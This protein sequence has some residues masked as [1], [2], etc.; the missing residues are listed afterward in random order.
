MGAKPLGKICVATPYRF[1]SH[2]NQDYSQ[3]SYICIKTTVKL[4]S[5]NSFYPHINHQGRL[6]PILLYIKTKF[7]SDDHLNGLIQLLDIAPL[8]LMISE[9]SF[10]LEPSSI[11]GSICLTKILRAEGIIAFYCCY[12]YDINIFWLCCVWCCQEDSEAF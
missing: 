2:L 4:H 1:Y 5:R 12:K 11:S 3:T 6:D 8:N 9:Y 10:R 7:C